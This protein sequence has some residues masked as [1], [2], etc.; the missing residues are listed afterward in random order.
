VG[1]VCRV[2]PVPQSVGGGPHFFCLG[3]N[4]APREVQVVISALIHR[5]HIELA[6]EPVWVGAGPFRDVGVSIEHLPIRLK[7][8]TSG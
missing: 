4:L 7:S 3:A 2:R 1:S 6:G 5:F 8:R